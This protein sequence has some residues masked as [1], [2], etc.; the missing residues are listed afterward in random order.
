MKLN[1]L[2]KV[3]L[4]VCMIVAVMTSAFAGTAWAQDTYTI[5][6]GRATGTE[7]T[8]TNFEDTSGSVEGKVSF[9]TAKNS[10]NNDPYYSSSNQEL[11]LYF[12]RQQGN[13]GSITLTPAEGITITG[14]VITTA[15]SNYSPSI[16]Y[17]ADGGTATSASASNNAGTYTYSI[18]G[19]SASSSLIIQNVTTNNSNNQLRIRTIQITVSRAETTTTVDASGIT[20]TNVNVSAPAGSLAA[21][22][23]AGGT[24]IEGATVTWSSSDESIATIDANTGEVTLLRNGTVDFIASYAGEWGKYGPSNGTY[25]M[26]VTGSN[27]PQTLWSE[28]W[29]GVSANATPPACTT[30]DAISYAYTGTTSVLNNNYAGGTAPEL[31]I[32]SGNGSFTATVPL[33]NV[34]G[35]LTLTYKTNANS[36]A[37]STTT[38]GITGG[39]SFNTSGTHT[40]TFTGITPEMTKIVIVFTNSSTSRNVRLDNIDLVGYAA[41]LE[42]AAPTFSVDAG[43]YYAPLSV[44]LSC[45]T[46]GATIYYSTD[47]AT[48]TEYTEAISVSA[49]TTIYAKAEKTNYYGVLYTSATSSAEYTILIPVTIAWIG[50]SSLYYSDKN[51][52]VPTGVEAYTYKEGDIRMV[53][54]HTYNEGD[55]IPAG[56]AVILK[57]EPDD[58]AFAESN[59]S[60]FVDGENKLQGS[61]DKAWTEP[62]TDDY[63]Y[64]VLSIKKN[65]NDAS[66]VGFYWNNS[67]GGKFENAAHKAYLALPKTSSVKSYYLFSEEDDPTGIEDVNVNLNDNESIYNVA[68]QRLNK[69]QKGIN[70]I[71]GKKILK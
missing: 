31:R 35:T 46:E 70:I 15:G 62:G 12:N 64:Y 68:G 39:G 29:T 61:D 27:P 10:S 37:V 4:R 41:P 7:G 56:T 17:S 3:W 60:G 52:I 34:Q 57:G 6:W 59:E 38:N 44:E 14:F 32:A 23:A 8:Y 11:R 45:A 66:T 63:Y 67:T 51:L 33:H 5:G 69:M 55:V 9:T 26:T 18:S 22:V 42:V 54:S 16:K 36:L 43:S 28:D 19:F 21:T 48:W 49:N 65:S 25:T 71:N 24:N 53:I 30:D 47:N 20:N 50:Y 58:Y 2:N 13:G 1:L 40:V